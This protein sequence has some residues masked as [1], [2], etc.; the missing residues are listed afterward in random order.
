MESVKVFLLL[1]P[2][3][4]FLGRQEMEER[5]GQRGFPLCNSPTPKINSTR[6]SARLLVLCADSGL[7][8]RPSPLSACAPFRSHARE[9]VLRRGGRGFLSVLPETRR[10]P[11][12]S[13]SRSQATTSCSHSSARRCKESRHAG[14]IPK[15][16]ALRR[17][18]CPAFSARAEKGWPSETYITQIATPACGL[19]RNGRFFHI[20][21]NSNL[22]GIPRKER[23]AGRLPASRLLFRKCCQKSVLIR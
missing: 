6:L 16:G 17:V 3:A 1:P 12:H 4:P 20:S 8:A 22:S 10:R 2:A 21:T 15:G 23:G 5:T 7:P 19:V 9:C 13:R 11:T 14:G 18:F